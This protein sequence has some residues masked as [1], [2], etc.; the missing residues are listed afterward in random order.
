MIIFF[1]WLSTALSAHYYFNV[2]G[3]P[4]TPFMGRVIRDF[5][6]IKNLSVYMRPTD[7]LNGIPP[8]AVVENDSLYLND[9]PLCRLEY[10]SACKSQFHLERVASGDGTRWFPFFDQKIV[11]GETWYLIGLSVSETGEGWIS[12]QEVP[13]AKT[14]GEILKTTNHRLI[15]TNSLYNTLIYPTL[16]SKPV[17]VA[18]EQSWYMCRGCCLPRNSDDFIKV[19]EV[20][21]YKSEEFARIEYDIYVYD[22]DSRSVQETPLPQRLSGTGY[23]KIIEKDFRLN[24]WEDNAY[25]H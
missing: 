18:Q 2:P 3:L 24:I 8:F 21:E 23:I 7:K 6:D 11:E 19:F 5:S 9:K 12:K 10:Y 15:F 14:I 4:D 20:V 13:G 1:I 17:E 25:C 16:T 22:L